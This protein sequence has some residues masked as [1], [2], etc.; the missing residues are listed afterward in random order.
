MRCFVNVFVNVFVNARFKQVAQIDRCRINAVVRDRLIAAQHACAVRTM[1]RRQIG[2]RIGRDQR[3][4]VRAVDEHAAIESRSA[5]AAGDVDAVGADA[6]DAHP[7]VFAGHA[8]RIEPHT[9]AQQQVVF[10][11]DQDARQRDAPAR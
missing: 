2:D 4:A 5:E 1:R 8:Q 10:L 3:A 7:V 9:V 11:S 6:V